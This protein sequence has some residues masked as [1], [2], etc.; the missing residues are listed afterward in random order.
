[1]TF[2][3]KKV[4]AAL[5]QNR[6]KIILFFI[7]YLF[8]IIDT[9][10]VKNLSIILNN[11]STTMFVFSY[12]FF[13]VLSLFTVKIFLKQVKKIKYERKPL[14]IFNFISIGAF[15]G[16]LTNVI[17]AHVNTTFERFIY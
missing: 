11:I 8:F 2:K 6:E 5:K 14:Q 16:F 9:S 1:M 12:T 17:N 4:I 13:L 10:F 15:I 3:S 7:G